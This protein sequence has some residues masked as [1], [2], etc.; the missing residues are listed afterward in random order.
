MLTNPLKLVVVDDDP[1]FLRFISDVIDGSCDLFLFEDGM[2]LIDHCHRIKPDV[3]LLDVVLPE[4]SGLAICRQIRSDRRFSGLFIALVS[5]RAMLGDIKRGIQSGANAYLTKP[6]HHER[7][8]L[9][10]ERCRQIVSSAQQHE[11]LFLAN[12]QLQV[13]TW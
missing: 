7:L 2:D 9:M 3:L 4:I 10:L 1:A 13:R 5:A 12:N 6:F 8:L 11:L